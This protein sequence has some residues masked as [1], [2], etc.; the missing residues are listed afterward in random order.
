MEEPKK[1]PKYKIFD[2]VIYRTMPPHNLNGFKV[3]IISDIEY[4]RDNWQYMFLNIQDSSRTP[5]CEENQII[6]K[7]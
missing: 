6:K 7:L 3:G 5:F 4:R 2:T 1:D